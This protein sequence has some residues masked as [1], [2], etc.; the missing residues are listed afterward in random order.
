M[1]DIAGKGCEILV[2][3][4]ERKPLPEIERK[5]IKKYEKNKKI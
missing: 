2:P 3:F 1:S 4:S 5:I